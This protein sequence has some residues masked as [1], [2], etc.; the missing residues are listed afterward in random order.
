[1]ARYRIVKY[2]FKSRDTYKVEKKV[3][4]F[5]YN[6]SIAPYKMSTGWFDT[7]EEA[8]HEI[9]N[10]KHGVRRDVIYISNLL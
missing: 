4:W 1:M 5:W 9:N 2:E 10:L 7:Y 3:L 6:A 8:M